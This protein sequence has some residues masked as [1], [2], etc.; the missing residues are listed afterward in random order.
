MSDI[1]INLT[2]NLT[3]DEQYLWDATGTPSPSIRAI[4]SA[5]GALRYSGRPLAIPLPRPTIRG[6]WPALAIA[7]V[8]VLVVIISL[9]FVTRPP[10]SIYGGW[11][12]AT[13]AGRPKVTRLE[14]K[15]PGNDGAQVTT[16]AASSAVLSLK[17]AIRVHL[18]PSS[19]A[20]FTG[21]PTVTLA[22]GQA[23]VEVPGNFQPAPTV[24]TTAF[25]CTLAPGCTATIQTKDGASQVTV[26]SG[27]AEVSSG[28]EKL[29]LA[30]SM[31]CSSHPKS[32]G[33]WPPYRIDKR[34]NANLMIKQI[35]QLLQEKANEKD[36][37]IRLE[38]TLKSAQPADAALL[39]NLLPRLSEWQ[40][41]AVRDRLA[42]LVKDP[43]KQPAFN[44][45]LK[46]DKD[47]MDAWWSA[48]VR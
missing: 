1:P 22:R 18:S 23:L 30:G 14:G 12:V 44:D 34:S 35:D 20:T 43:P 36:V 40:R 19:E 39:W 7:A 17:Q 47:A 5:L 10:V 4:E 25:G 6:R 28:D 8:L 9:Y 24:S 16:D 46:L 3:P 33:I 11:T 42:Q 45:V 27:W 29:R 13:E 32:G 38:E 37:Y 15:I 41:S 31:S 21:G 26:K 2:G 48:I